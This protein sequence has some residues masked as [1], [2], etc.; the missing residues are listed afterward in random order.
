MAAGPATSDLD[1]TEHGGELAPPRRSTRGPGR[2]STDRVAG[3][4]RRNLIRVLVVLIAAA[5]VATGVIASG[6]LVPSRVV[7]GVTGG[8]EEAASTKLEAAGLEAEVARR[9]YR[10]DTDP[11]QVLA[12]DPPAGEMRKANRPVELTVSRG[13]PPVAVPDLAGRTQSEAQ[14]ALEGAGL[15]LGE[16][17]SEFNANPKGTVIHWAPRDVDAT[18]G[19]KVNL[20]VSDGPPPVLM[21]DLAGRPVPEAVAANRWLEEI[22][23]SVMASIPADLRGRLDDAEIFHEI[24]EHRWFMS[25]AAG[26]DIGTTAAAGDYLARVLPAVPGDLVAGT[27]RRDPNQTTAPS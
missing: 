22:Y 2:S 6:V 17:A 16:V 11:G 14:A 13:P 25:E 7:P 21:P 8:T 26:K 20:V 3:K 24:L 23:G 4:G 27:V 19:S 10:D 18:K 12:Q 5:L 1:R 9:V 15:A